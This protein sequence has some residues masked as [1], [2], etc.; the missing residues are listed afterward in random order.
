MELKDIIRTSRERLQMRQEDLAVAVGVTKQAVQQ[1]EAGE[2]S[3]RGSRRDR[4][5]EVLRIEK[6]VQMGYAYPS[7]ARVR[8]RVA[9]SLV[10]NIDRPPR[11]SVLDATLAE[12]RHA[13]PET[14]APFV[15]QPVLIRQQPYH[16]HYYSPRL[17]LHIVNGGFAGVSPLTLRNA[18]WRLAVA[19]TAHNDFPISTHH[20][21]IAVL[22]GPE[23]AHT[24]RI[25]KNFLREL[26]IMDIKPLQIPD[27][28][29]LAAAI[30]DLEKKPT[31]YDRYVEAH[32][33]L[34]D[35]ND[36]EDLL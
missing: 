23:G 18:A 25:D 19:R 20:Y 16:F 12:L 22:A 1:W 35:D 36:F 30:I 15:S 29:G 3:P 5:Y 24:A 6:P 4:L 11:Q 10:A 2:T 9:E 26:D 32:Q 14:L 21:V 7:E 27:P 28:Q 17:L 34:F 13:L 33:D 8:A 31:D